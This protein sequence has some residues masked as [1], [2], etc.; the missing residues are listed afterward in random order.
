M[1]TPHTR[2]QFLEVVAKSGLLPPDVLH[3]YPRSV[4]NGPDGARVLADRLIKDRLLTS[5]QVQQL[6]AGKSRGFFLADKF[7]V[8][9]IISNGAM[10]PVILAEN[11]RSQKLVAIKLLQKAA[12]EE[13]TSKRVAL[14]RFV[15]ETR[16]SGILDH[17]NI[18]R[19]QE[20]ERAGSAPFL[21]MDY[22][23]GN[24]LQEIVAHL[25]PLD[26]QRAVDYIRQAAFG[27]QHAHGNQ[28]IHRDI[29]PAHLILNRT[30][31]VRVIDLGLAEFLGDL[32]RNSRE[33]TPTEG[34]TPGGFGDYISPEQISNEPVDQRSDIYSLGATLYFLLAGRAPFEGEPVAA[35]LNAQQFREP[36]SIRELRPDVP[37]GLAEV[38]DRMIAKNPNDRY[39][40]M[41]GVV[42]ALSPWI[43]DPLPPPSVDEMPP[44]PPSAY[45]LGLI[46][47]SAQSASSVGPLAEVRWGFSGV[48]DGG[49]MEIN[50]RGTRQMEAGT[51]VAPRTAESREDDIRTMRQT[52][53]APPLNVARRHAEMPQPSGLFTT[54]PPATVADP[55]PATEPSP[56]TLP[57]HAVGPPAAA[58]ARSTRRSTPILF[59]VIGLAVLLTAGAIWWLNAGT[60]AQN[61]SG[62]TP[63]RSL[64]N[65]P[66]PPGQNTKPPTPPNKNNDPPQTV[67]PKQPVQP[68]VAPA[69][70]NVLLTGSGSTFIKSAMEHWTR[71]YEQKSGVKIK[72]DG[73]G[74]GR[75]VENMIDKVLDFGCTDA[76]MTDAQIAKARNANGEVIHIPLA[77]GPV[78]VTYNLPEIKQQ[79][80]FTG[81][82][83]ADI[84]LGKIRNWNHE[85]I[86]AS[87]PGVTLPDKEITVIRRSDSSGTTF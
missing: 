46:S 23:D 81:S 34:S 78:V 10:G 44:I 67:P 87:N 32:A 79:L 33:T 1:S 59:G 82:V 15:R 38:L 28:I 54:I 31:V 69:T 45:R 60:A 35:K 51:A 73:I 42:A 47:G 7:K 8:L 68:A 41:K 52:E 84:Y 50:S 43:R 83:L 64:A 36:M 5:F 80:R 57:Q 22:V 3:S 48:S 30:G 9:T 4:G 11:L 17:P 65:A 53:L 40:T 21:V 13:A 14:E 19:V 18:V 66:E 71:L 29:K 72:Y 58:K 61:S 77:M 75:G 39:Q 24:N 6:L 85:A 70:T 25:G 37:L 74:S 56:A 12:G 76:F 63:S 26:P 27:L 16:E 86:A 2:E 62:S 55:Q 49:G 20:M